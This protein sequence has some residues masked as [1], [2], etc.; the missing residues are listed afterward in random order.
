LS[1]KRRKARDAAA[2]RRRI[3]NAATAEFARYGF[4]GARVDRISRRARTFDRM[5]YYYYGDKI[6]LF[7][8]VLENTYEE[9]WRAEEALKL[10]GVAPEAGI[11]ELVAF[12]WRYFVAHPEFIRLLNSENLQRGHNVRR[13]ARVGRLSSPF[14]ATL[15]D[16]L[17]R[18][19]ARGVFRR[20]IHPV[21]LYITIAAL[22][23]FYVANRYTLSHFLSF[24][25]MAKPNQEA[26]L[27][28]I[29]EVV[30]AGMRPRGR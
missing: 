12:T 5:L 21:R 20:G 10:S 28:H 1:A 13:S 27:E 4:A 2:T 23:Y 15:E 11:R 30:L 22:A 19:Q 6:S 9:L 18:G 24:D 16:L 29:T 25:L 7:R 17:R 3:L 8:V 26:W 14:I